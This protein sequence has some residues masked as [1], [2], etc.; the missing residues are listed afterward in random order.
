MIR[1]QTIVC[2][3]CGANTTNHENCE[4]CGSL[5][6]RFEDK[7]IEFDEDNYNDPGIVDTK[8][9][10]IL[11][12]HLM[13]A[14]QPGIGGV[15]T[16]IA[17]SDPDN[18]AIAENT[19][20]YVMNGAYLSR[21]GLYLLSPNPSE[22]VIEHWS[23]HKNAPYYILSQSLNEKG[24]GKE[25]DGA[26]KF[27]DTSS[28]KL[29]DSLFILVKPFFT[30]SDIPSINSSRWEPSMNLIRDSM[31]NKRSIQRKDFA[32]LLSTEVHRF[33]D[34]SIELCVMDFGEDIQGAASIISQ[35][36]NDDPDFIGSY[37]ETI[38]VDSPTKGTSLFR[39][40]F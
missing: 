4:F 11:S 34:Y 8:L 26:I 7:N 9:G 13:T 18:L 15:C 14:K 16:H 21:F 27:Y 29:F 37:M 35:M 40:L 28:T 25:Y 39:K 5:L 31:I 33:D 20:C 36:N 23:G 32:K 12:V 2:P 24:Q 38:P 1:L 19:I 6:V 3:N 17:E 22:E 10:D 30:F